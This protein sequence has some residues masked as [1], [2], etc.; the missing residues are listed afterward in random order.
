MAAVDITNPQSWNRYAYVGNNPL[1]SLD[2]TGLGD[3]P[4]PSSQS[5]AVCQGGYFGWSMFLNFTFGFE[6][7]LSTI[8]VPPDNPIYDGPVCFNCSVVLAGV[9]S[10]TTDLQC[11]SPMAFCNGASAANNGPTSQLPGIP[12]PPNPIEN[13]STK[14]KVCAAA[15][16]AVTYFGF[17]AG[18]GALS[19]VAVP[20]IITGG[21]TTAGEVG[22]FVIAPEVAVP[23]LA[24]GV[25]AALL[26]CL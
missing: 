2:P 23:V 9:V 22:G 8:L 13:P 20:S 24:V 19:P 14:D 7:P 4:I 18:P 10:P 26:L 11:Y 16:A 15:G 25:P 5:Q 6:D 12:K 1:D 3:C 21:L 17:V